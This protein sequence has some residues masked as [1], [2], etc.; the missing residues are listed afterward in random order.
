[1]RLCGHAQNQV[2]SLRGVHPYGDRP[3]VGVTLLTV[4]F[5]TPFY[6]VGCHYP[7]ARQG[8]IRKQDDFVGISHIIKMGKMLGQI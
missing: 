2:G 5:A 1:M 8:G 3:K 4:F 6:L 7:D